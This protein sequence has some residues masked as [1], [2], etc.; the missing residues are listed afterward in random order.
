MHGTRYKDYLR[1]PPINGK[2]T[3]IGTHTK[4]FQKN[5]LQY[6]AMPP[7]TFRASLYNH[8]IIKRAKYTRNSLKKLTN[9]PQKLESTLPSLRIAEIFLLAD[10]LNQCNNGRFRCLFGG[11]TIKTN[12]GKRGNKPGFF[13]MPLD[14]TLFSTPLRSTKNKRPEVRHNTPRG[15]ISVL[16][17]TLIS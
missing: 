11:P 4:L 10:F 14:G 3:G 1:S 12:L 6:I 9:S 16:E 17:V 8:K 5:D 15:G 7:K 2:E 13:S